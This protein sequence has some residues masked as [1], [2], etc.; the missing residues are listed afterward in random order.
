MAPPDRAARRGAVIPVFVFDRALLH[1][2]ETAPARVAFML[3]DAAARC[4]LATGGWQAFNFRTRACYASFLSNL[5]SI[6]WRYGALHFMRHLIDGDCPIDHYQWAMQ[7]GITS[8][9]DKSWT[10]IYNPGQAAVDRFDPQGQFIKRWVPELRHLRPDQLGSPPATKGYP[11]PIL[12]YKQARAQRVEQLGRQRQMFTQPQADIVPYLAPLPAS[13]VP[14]GSDRVSCDVSWATGDNSFASAE[15]ELF[16]AAIDLSELDAEQ[17]AILRSWFMA[18][19][20]S[21]SDRARLQ[22]AET[23]QLQ[24]L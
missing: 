19:V 4:L 24:L 13:F 5:L 18:P 2:P 17:A 23:M 22:A 15:R 8:A 9:I 3:E 14:F 7:A 11:A 16:P 10:R 12:D 20:A 6:D 1:H 21:S